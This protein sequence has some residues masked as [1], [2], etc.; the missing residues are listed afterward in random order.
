MS[1]EASSPPPSPPFG[2]ERETESWA[3]SRFMVQCAQLS[4]GEF[5]PRLSPPLRG[6][7]GEDIARSA[8]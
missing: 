4:F 3:V 6:G 5:S 7:E 8:F 1:P 2:E